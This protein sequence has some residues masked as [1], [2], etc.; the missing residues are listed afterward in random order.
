MIRKLVDCYQ[1]AGYYQVHWDA[2]DE[3]GMK[4]PSGIYF[5]QIRANEFTQIKKMTLLK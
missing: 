3:N 4:V 1:S 2:T 5:Y